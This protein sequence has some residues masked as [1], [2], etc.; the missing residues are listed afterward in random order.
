MAKGL[1]TRPRVSDDLA[2]SISYGILGFG[3]IVMACIVMAY[4]V[5]A[6]PRVSDDLASSISRA[7]PEL[8]VS[9]ALGGATSSALGGATCASIGVRTYVRSRVEGLGCSAYSLRFRGWGSL[10]LRRSG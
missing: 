1:S 10:L 6:R 3:I 4:I 2:S 5:M 8:S 9:S 7:S